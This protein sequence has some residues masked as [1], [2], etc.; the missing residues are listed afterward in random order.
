MK[1]A[2][3]MD[4]SKSFPVKIGQK[5]I[6]NLATI[7]IRLPSPPAA[8]AFPDWRRLQSE[9]LVSIPSA[10]KSGFLQMITKLCRCCAA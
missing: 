5:L 2:D 3:A 1:A 7:L 6:A 4:R 9:Y 10:L 8:S